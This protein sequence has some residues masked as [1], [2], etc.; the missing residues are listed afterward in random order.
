MS[1]SDIDLRR[2][3]VWIQYVIS[4]SVVAI[5]VVAAWIVGRDRPVPAWITHWLIPILGWIYL[6]LV[7]F[8]IWRRWR[9]GSNGGP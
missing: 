5:V 9:R 8:V 4:L 2:L 3:P 1:N 6:M 7:A